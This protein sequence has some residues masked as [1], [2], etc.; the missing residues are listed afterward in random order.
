MNKAREKIALYLFRTVSTRGVARHRR[1]RAL[2]L[3]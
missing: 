1:A 3:Q 2:G